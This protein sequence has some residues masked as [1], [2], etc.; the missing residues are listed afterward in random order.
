MEKEYQGLYNPEMYPSAYLVNRI[1]N[2]G[3]MFPGSFGRREKRILMEIIRE[4]GFDCE[5]KCR[6]TGSI[7]YIVIRYTRP[8]ET[9]VGENGILKVSD[10]WAN[11]IEQ[12][13]LFLNRYFPDMIGKFIDSCWER[14]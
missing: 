4:F 14:F 13:E 10:W 6:P 11:D 2:T 7:P 5:M 3:K 8:D 9:E 12:I 1:R